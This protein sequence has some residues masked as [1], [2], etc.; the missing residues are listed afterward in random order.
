MNL[1]P[2]CANPTFHTKAYL[3]K[4]GRCEACSMEAGPKW[5]KYPRTGRIGI[6][7]GSPGWERRQ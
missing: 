4:H 6:R 2:V 5:G 7:M 3:Q 1:C